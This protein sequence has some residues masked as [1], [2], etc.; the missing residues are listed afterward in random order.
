MKFW[1]LILLIIKLFKMT[2]E[3]LKLKCI[4]SSNEDLEVIYNSNG[5]IIILSDEDEIGYFFI[6]LSLQDIED[7]LIFAKQQEEN[8]IK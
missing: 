8:K 6:E 3:V 2:E 5:K 7:I 4:S 1:K